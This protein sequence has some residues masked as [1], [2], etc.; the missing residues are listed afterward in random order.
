MFAAM[1]FIA[2][3]VITIMSG[4]L[5]YLATAFLS[6]VFAVWMFTMFAMQRSGRHNIISSFPFTYALRWIQLLVFLKAFGEV[7]IL[8][9]YRLATGV[10]ETVERRS[11]RTA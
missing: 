10:W 6:D 3:P 2:I 4:T 1:F 9:R 5:L 7:F 11:H 8:R